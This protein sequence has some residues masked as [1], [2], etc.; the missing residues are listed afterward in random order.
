MKISRRVGAGLAIAVLVASTSTALA[1]NPFAKSTTT[2]GGYQTWDSDLINVEQVSQ[3]GAGV[4]VAVLDTGL[5]PNWTD[6][7]PKERVRTDLGTGFEQQVN[8]K[9]ATDS[10]DPCGVEVEKGQLRQSTWV[11]SRGSSHATHV[12]STII[13]YSYYS[14]FDALGGYALPP[15]QVR[16]IAPN[17]TIIPV[18]VL[19]DYQVPALPKCPDPALQKQ[20]NVV[21]GTDEMVAAGIDYVT[22]LKKGVL[23]G[24]PVVI[25]MSLG[26]PELAGVEKAA[27]DAAIAA[28][29]II[30]AAAGNEGTAGMG[31]P[32]AYAPVISVGSAGW[33]REWLD[34]P[35]ATTKV[36]PVGGRYRMWWLQNTLGTGAVGALQPPLKPNSGQVLDP[37]PVGQVYVSDFSSRQLTGQDL[38]VLAP[39]SWV[40]GPLPGDGNYAHLPW[41]SGGIGDVKGRN[42]G[43]FYYVG[44]TSMATPHVASL[45]AL[46]LQKDPTLTQTEM[47]AL[48]ES[49]AMRIPAGTA[50]VWDISPAPGWTYPTWGTDATGAGLVNAEALLTAVP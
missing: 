16:G 8:F 44:G 38:D 35:A 19:S 31:Y 39:G 2:A 45:A 26:G 20:G 40:R 34:N 4:Y 18:K 9:A 50:K 29:V 30:V 6:Y 10:K 32:G 1:G 43:N 11:G 37:T 21:F 23:K 27:I 22:S 42:P 41:W 33:D 3:T 48:L 36:A 47:E 7:F 25:N 15:I 14:N 49:T 12:T 5:V 13:G 46:A 24:K 17:A 28:G